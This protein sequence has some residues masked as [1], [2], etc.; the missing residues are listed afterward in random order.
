MFNI[1]QSNTFVLI[2]Y[3]ILW[4]EK[5]SKQW[6]ETNMNLKVWN[7]KETLYEKIYKII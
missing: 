4:N 6:F 1:F 2:A 7:F 3:K 5:I